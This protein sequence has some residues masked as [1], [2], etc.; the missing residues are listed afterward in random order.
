MG[1]FRLKIEYLL[2]EV[3]SPVLPITQNFGLLK[4]T[5]VKDIN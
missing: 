5:A 1:Q 2:F 4:I 3:L